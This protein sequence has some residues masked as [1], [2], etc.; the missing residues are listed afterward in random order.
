M[1]GHE[2]WMSGASQVVYTAIM[3]NMG[4]IAPNANFTSPDDGSAG[5]DIV[6]RALPRP[7]RRALL[8]AAGFG[9]TNSSLVV[10]FG[11]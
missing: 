5:L 8:N 10:G 11:P 7:P 1:T 4:F 3:A 6:T 9:G 2:L